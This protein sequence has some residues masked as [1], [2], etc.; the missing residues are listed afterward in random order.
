MVGSHTKWS[1]I[2]KGMEQSPRGAETPEASCWP[3]PCQR[4]T[5]STQ[6]GTSLVTRYHHGRREGKAHSPSLPHIPQ[7]PIPSWPPSCLSPTSGGQDLLHGRGA[8][9]KPRGRGL[10]RGLGWQVGP[11]PCLS[12]Q[13]SEPRARGTRGQ[14]WLPL[15]L[16]C[17]PLQKSGDWG[18]PHHR[19]EGVHR[20]QEPAGPRPQ[21]GVLG[22]PRPR[23]TACLKR[24]KRQNTAGLPLQASNCRVQQGL[25]SLPLVPSLPDP[26]PVG[27]KEA[28]MPPARSPGQSLPS[29]QRG[30][31]RGGWLPV[32]SSLHSP[33]A[34][35]SPE[36]P[37]GTASAVLLALTTPR[38]YLF[39]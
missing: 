39:P 9:M 16:V 19:W 11:S 3:R 8:A 22:L 27:R 2:P 7:T 5:Q 36:L 18:G 23:P 33:Q 30:A 38:I 1:H 24:M 28:H 10:R 26:G 17:V 29:D 31:G 13:T 32:D 6:G 4:L 12:F 14:T 20:A 35:N 15:E 25:Q 34:P 37:S 21:L